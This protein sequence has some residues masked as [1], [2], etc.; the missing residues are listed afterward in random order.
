MEEDYLKEGVILKKRYRTGK[1]LGTGGFGITYL[2]DDEALGQTVVIK[3]FF[4]GRSRKRKRRN[5][6][7]APKREKRQKTFP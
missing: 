7:S 2:A 5:E 6:S 1:I 3:E 4:R